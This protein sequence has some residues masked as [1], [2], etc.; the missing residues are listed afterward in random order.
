LA[1]KI[2]F[3]CAGSSTS[4]A[5]AYLYALAKTGG[6][7]VAIGSDINGAAALPGPRFGPFAAFGAQGDK[8]RL[9]DRRREIDEQVNGV[10]YDEPI[11]D[12][13]WH[14]FEAAD[15]G[16]YDDEE[17]DIWQA[18]AQ[19]EA[20]FNPWIHKHPHWDSPEA[21]VKRARE[22]VHLLHDQEHVDEMARGFYAADLRIPV[23]LDQLDDWPVHRRAGY[24]ARRAGQSPA[25]W[26]DE[27]T[28]KL[29]ARI[30]TIWVKW[31]QMHGNNPPLKRS[32][33]GPRRDF[34]YNI[35]GMAHY[36]MLPDFLQDLRNIGLTPEDLAPLF[37]GAYDYITMW[38]KAEDR[39]RGFAAAQS[40]VEKRETPEP[41]AAQ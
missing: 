38:E 10:A 36:G 37:R 33:A 35:D 23:S 29:A 41:N 1:S 13:R 17:E 9:A 31:N 5:Q 26:Q 2:P 39:A 19:Y 34:D 7:G 27:A 22:V 21:S 15:P 14:R 30:N 18:I 3:V 8:G 40:A 12:Y 28:R 32:K 24:L 4:W 25:K 20:G 6:R 11:I 16:A